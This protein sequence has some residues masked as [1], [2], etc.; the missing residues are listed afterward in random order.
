MKSDSLEESHILYFLYVCSLLDLQPYIVLRV[1][2]GRFSKRL[3]TA[4]I[5]IGGCDTSSFEFV[6]LGS[7]L[8]PPKERF[9]RYFPN[10]KSIGSRLVLERQLVTRTVT[11]PILP[12]QLFNRI[13][14][15]II[16]HLNLIYIL[17]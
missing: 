15:Q 12:V 16:S 8:K 14:T 4:S 3:L 10:Q 17:M 1:G 6:D 5:Q 11:K 7:C 9:S 13:A 2:F